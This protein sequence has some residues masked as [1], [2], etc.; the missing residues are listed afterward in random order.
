[1][2]QTFSRPAPALPAARGDALLRFACDRIREWESQ[3]A[4]EAAEYRDRPLGA[5]MVRYAIDI[6]RL[7][8][9]VRLVL[10]DYGETRD[11]DPAAAAVIRRS[12]RDLAMAWRNH[13]DWRD[14]WSS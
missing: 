9:A 12:T 1:M 14:E 4:T 13:P 10:A 2:D 7:C 11:T 8:S 5:A 3:V 6:R